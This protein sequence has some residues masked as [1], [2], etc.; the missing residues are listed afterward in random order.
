MPR[1]AAS[2][3]A[4][5]AAGGLVFMTILSMTDLGLAAA[6]V[7]H[8]HS[9]IGVAHL[10][11]STFSLVLASCTCCGICLISGRNGGEDRQAVTCAVLFF[12]MFLY[13][14]M[15]IPLS[16]NHVSK[17]DIRAGQGQ[18]FNKSLED[19]EAKL[20]LTSHPYYGM[21]V[22]DLIMICKTA[23]GFIVLLIAAGCS[24]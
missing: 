14:A 5:F 17:P 24:S 4:A 18:F 3:T 21:F 20:A 10:V 15:V 9:K 12:N 6:A 16:V 19:N 7:A 11:V 23:F 13:I 8:D 1:K 22:V 2:P